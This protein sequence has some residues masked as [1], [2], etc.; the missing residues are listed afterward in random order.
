MGHGGGT[1]LLGLYEEKPSLWAVLRR[2]ERS[3]L[4]AAVQEGPS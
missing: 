1:V 3:G 4:Y 2:V